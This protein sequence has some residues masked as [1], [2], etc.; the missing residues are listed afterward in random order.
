VWWCDVRSNLFDGLEPRLG[1]RGV[2][3]ED[4]AASGPEVH[5]GVVVFSEPSD[6]TSFAGMQE[7]KKKL[8]LYVALSQSYDLNFYSY[9]ASVVEGYSVISK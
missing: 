4:V 9:S 8:V 3:V 5:G 1:G 7:Q 6:N 2:V